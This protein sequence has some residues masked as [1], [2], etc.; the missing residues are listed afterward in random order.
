MPEILDDG[1][2]FRMSRTT[3]DY[4]TLWYGPEPRI[5]CGLCTDELRY[6]EAKGRRNVGRPTSMEG[7]VF[8]LE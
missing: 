5:V 2:I 3:G 8:I 1:L 6:Y 7:P 4:S